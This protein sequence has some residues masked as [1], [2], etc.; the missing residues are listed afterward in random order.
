MSGDLPG[1]ASPPRPTCPEARKAQG[2]DSLAALQSGLLG[3]AGG[4]Y[5][6]SYRTQR[7]N[8]E[9]HQ[10]SKRQAAPRG[11]GFTLSPILL[12][13]TLR[14]AHLHS[15]RLTIWPPGVPLGVRPEALNAR[16]VAE[17]LRP[18]CRRKHRCH[19]R[20]AKAWAFQE[21]PARRCRYAARVCLRRTL[22]ETWP[23]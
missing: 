12:A 15:I 14:G 7:R 17:P 19:R 13:A 22:R 2:D 9:G 8:G 1:L 16:P 4:E 3:E 23:P 10:R 11:L 18:A 21:R 20:L 5:Q 6:K